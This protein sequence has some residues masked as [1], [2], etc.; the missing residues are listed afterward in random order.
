MATAASAATR[1]MPKAWD[2]FTLRL[3]LEAAP[4]RLVGVDRN[5]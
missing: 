4:R 5:V 1:T 2:R 3:L